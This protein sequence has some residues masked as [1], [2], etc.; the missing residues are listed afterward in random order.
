MFLRSSELAVRVRAIEDRIA[1]LDALAVDV[2]APAQ[3]TPPSPEPSVRHAILS[4]LLRVVRWC[5][6]KRRC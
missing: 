2:E 3:A 6:G 1:S 5:M 4:A